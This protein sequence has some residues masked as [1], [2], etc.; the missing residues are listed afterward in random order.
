MRLAFSTL[1]CPIWNLDTVLTRAVEYG[2][3][4][5]EL[6]GIGEALDIG[7][8][9][10]F[11]SGIAETADRFSQA[12]LTLTCLDTSA[13]AVALT[14][15]ERKNNL[16]E[17]RRYSRMCP[18]F[19]TPFLRVFGGWFE[20]LPRGEA[21]AI[22]AKQLREMAT[23]ADDGQARIVIETHDKW[24]SAADVAALLDAANDDRVG[25]LWDTHHTYR[26]GNETPAETWSVLGKRVMGTHLKDSG[27]DAECDDNSAYCLP[28][29]GDVP[30]AEIVNR[31]LTGGYTGYLTF[32]WEKRWRPE[33][34]G[35]EVALP[36]YVDVMQRMSADV[37][38]VRR[39]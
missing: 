31:L 12:G 7:G 14:E 22:A 13:R 36:A 4:G 32:E 26:I 1:G 38:G 23:I 16:D 10:E 33:L 11:D 37:M 21:I 15:G 19:K 6:R 3:D 35:P 39:E 5:V 29:E 27:F 28:G 18:Y 30:L 9:R 34:A 2:Y 8:M 24:T 17:I 20:N 25:V